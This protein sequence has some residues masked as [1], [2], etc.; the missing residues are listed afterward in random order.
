MNREFLINILFLVAINLLIKPFYIFGIDRT[1]QNTVGSDQYGLYFALFSLAIIFQVVN[2]LGIQNYNSRT[3]AQHP[4][5]LAKYY[6]RLFGLKI[7][8][9]GVYLLV[10][11]GVAA[12]WGYS[13]DIWPILLFL[14]LTQILSSFVFYLRSN[15]AG[16]GWYRTDSMLSALDRL[17]L[18]FMVGYLL[19]GR[20]GGKPF[21]I[22]WFVYAQTVSMFL[23]ALVAFAVLSGRLPTWRPKFE[24]RFWGSLIRR[25]FP[26]ALVVLLMFLYTR[27]DGVMLE[28]LLTDGRLEAGIYASAYRLLD[29]SNMFGFLAAGLLLPMFSKILKAKIPVGS[30]VHLSF[31]WI[32]VGAIS[33]SVAVIGFQEEIVYALYR[34][35]TPYWGQVLALLMVAFVAVSGS[36][37]YGTLLTANGSLWRMNRVFA[38]SILLNIGLNTWWIPEYK[39]YGAALATVITQFF[40]LIAQIWIARS[41]LSVR[42]GRRQLLL[43]LLFVSL[44][45]GLVWGWQQWVRG[46]WYLGFLGLLLA[47][48]LFAMALRLIRLQEVL[49]VVRDKRS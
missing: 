22:E 48:P 30:L 24:P 14:T 18:I 12:V 20:P 31:Q 10:I 41:E 7:A 26:Y 38:I 2:D 49:A 35:A 34:E 16:I 37:I 25:S 36:Y 39:A 29:A 11:F 13:W 46:P 23:T 28:R 21:Q 40:V 8:L 42:P 1:V 33:L 27:I 32:L 4:Q 45:L 44:L 19:W 15:I 43:L 6:P 3:I 5:L 47:G 9:S 17:L